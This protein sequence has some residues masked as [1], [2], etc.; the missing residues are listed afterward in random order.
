MVSARSEQLDIPALETWLWDAACTI[1]GATDAPKFKDFIL[2]LIFYKRLSDVFDDEVAKHVASF[3]SEDVARTV[4][5]QDHA[6]A[7]RTGRKPIVRFF[8]PIA[9]QWDRIRNHG[10]NGKLGEF[11]TTAMRETARLNTDLQ[12]VL[13]VKDFNERQSGQRTLDD[14]RLAA[15]I[16]II[17]R[18]RLGLQNTEPDVLGRAYE[19]L[20]RKFAEGQGQS[21]GEFYTPKEVGFLMADLLDPQPYTEIHDPT[22][23]SGGLLL[24]PRLRFEQQ[25]PTQ[26]S[27]APRLF[28][29]ELNPIT[30]AMAKMNMFLHD[31]TDSQ[32]AIGDTF[33]NPRFASSGA[34]LQRFDYVVANP[35][36]NQDNY[37]EA[38]YDADTWGRF[39]AGQPPGS[40][41][42]W[43]WV[44]HILACLKDGGRAAI[45]LDT[46]AVSRGSGSKS[47]N[48]EKTIR[49]AL[50]EQDM[51]E[52]VV[53]LPENLFYNTT[54]PGIIL[55]LRRRKPEARKG[56]ILLVNASAYFVKRK[57]KNELTEE[58][59]AA[60]ADTYRAWI[61]RE[62]LSQVITLEEARAADYNL[63]PSQFVR[64][65][66]RA[67]H[68]P[69][70]AIL[71]DIASAR[72]E[73]EHADAELARVV[74]RLGL[75]V[76]SDS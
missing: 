45:V 61:S 24:K 6:D 27:Q 62:K 8:V 40:S 21:A 35:M 25:C 2:P 66:D 67:Q 75:L 16:E 51:I 69:L 11:V 57:P 76:S 50:V 9:Y 52:G 31:Y 33:T 55:L 22:C 49:A 74:E 64:V 44:Q 14:D 15:L 10:A 39:G 7:L 53:L 47:A 19:Y 59:I 37:D 41:A 3:G 46:G 17:S 72:V 58:G 30:Y 70:D 56:Q 32:I 71:A 13:D 1:R 73:R 60:I 42:D 38:F 26:R 65:A 68:R 43:G 18:H 23:G 48:K 28:G 4:I 20:L 34:G 12:G 36:W 54:A 63:S 5:E 29:Q